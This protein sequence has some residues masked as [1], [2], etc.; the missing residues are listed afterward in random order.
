MDFFDVV[1]KRR[2]VRAYTGEPVSKNDL[3]HI[4][5]AGRQAPSGFN[6]QG[7]CFVA[8]TEKSMIEK[9]AALTSEWAAQAGAMIAVVMDPEIPF[10]THDAS[11]ATENILLAA[12]ALGYGT[13]WL[14]GTTRR[15]DKEIKVL[16]SI[17]EIMQLQTI[18]TV[19]K[20][21]DWPEGKKK[22]LE[23]V[24]RWEKYSP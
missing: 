14:E 3:I 23:E 8:I 6:R 10:L 2:T 16:L 18:I 13:C 24:L 15:V 12:T 22:S 1:K 19:G 5:D 20:A 7:W 11:A 4:I 9:I 17:P 21:V